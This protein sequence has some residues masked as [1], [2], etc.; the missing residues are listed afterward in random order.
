[1]P[2][3]LYEY[4]LHGF[5]HKRPNWILM[6]S[7]TFKFISA[8]R[9]WLV[10]MIFSAVIHLHLRIHS[11]KNYSLISLHVSTLISS[12]TLFTSTLQ[13]MNQFIQS[14]LQFL[15]F[16]LT[17]QLT[18]VKH[19]YT[20]LILIAAQDFYH[21]RRVQNIKKGRRPRRTDDPGEGPKTLE[22][23]KPPALASSSSCSR[24]SW[25]VQVG[26]CRSHCRRL[27]L[28]N[29]FYPARYTLN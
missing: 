25:T 27:K 19:F 6:I 15:Q 5:C 26:N 10:C 11:S 29:R 20:I 1:M 4:L 24:L 12:I 13:M 16:I 7:A 2:L 18:F 22:Y 14:T 28:V 23:P 9:R 17:I 3:I 21:H 8:P